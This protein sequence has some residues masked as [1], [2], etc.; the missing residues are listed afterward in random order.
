M[1]T[2]DH[3]DRST[4]P[5]LTKFAA[6]TVFAAGLGM[7]VMGL[8]AAAANADPAPPSTPDPNPAITATLHPTAPQNPH[9]ESGLCNQSVV[10]RGAPLP[11]PGYCG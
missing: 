1:T 9:S 6:R 5:K 10:P 11:P 7:A 4:Q 8:T 3:L 2:T